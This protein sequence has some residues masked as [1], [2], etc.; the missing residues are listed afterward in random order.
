M[1]EHPV[2]GWE[3][4]L[5]DPKYRPP[6]YY[7][8]MTPDFATKEYEFPTPTPNANVTAYDGSTWNFDDADNRWMMTNYPPT[9][10][11]YSAVKARERNQPD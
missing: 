5:V 6:A 8:T 10:D 1:S 11:P 3:R 4:E 7:H 2:T 9:G